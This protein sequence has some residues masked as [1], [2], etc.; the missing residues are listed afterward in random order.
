MLIKF[1]ILL[2]LMSN[3][4]VIHE[5]EDRPRYFNEIKRVLKTSGLLC[6]IYWEKKEAEMGP[7]IN[8]RISKED[9]IKTCIDAN[10]TYLKDVFIN[11]DHY[12]LKFQL[13]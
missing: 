11:I 13:V 3:N 4:N 9:M 2:T 7:P 6:I 8:E 1:Y 12:G 10:F 5:I